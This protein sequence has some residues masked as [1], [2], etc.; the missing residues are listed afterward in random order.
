MKQ[1]HATLLGCAALVLIMVLVGCSL[2]SGTNDD[3]AMTPDEEDFGLGV[4]ITN[5][6]TP[7]D[8]SPDTLQEIVDT[9][10]TVPGN[11]VITLPPGTT[12]TLK[13]T[14]LF[15]LGDGV[16]VSLRGSGTVTL[17]SNDHMWC[18]G[19]GAKLTIR[20]PEL[21]GKAGNDNS[22]VYVNEASLV[23]C[24]GNITGN[25]GGGVHILGAGASFVMNGGSITGNTAI[26]GGGVHILSNARFTMNGG[27]IT[28][29][30]AAGPGTPGAG[31]V[32]F[33]RGSWVIGSG[34]SF[35]KDGGTISGNKVT[36]EDGVTPIPGYG[37]EVY[38]S[39]HQGSTNGGEPNTK[40]RRRRESPAG[41][42]VRLSAF[43]NADKVN[44]GA[45]G[46]WEYVE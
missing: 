36:Q 1:K 24:S 4:T 31:G 19:K 3:K 18:L 30:K 34:G 27:A 28:G 25:K 22:L 10:R 44:H 35:T 7:G 23:L 11:Y 12:H 40:F 43:A 2:P 39:L 8:T 21:R 33:V 38:V 14:S 5:S 29:N 32:C 45:D 26:S 6:Y 17:P 15:A 41:T 46:A 16:T 37:N 20:G 9:I 42:S 13:M